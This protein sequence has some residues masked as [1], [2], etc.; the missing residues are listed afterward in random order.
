MTNVVGVC[1]NAFMKKILVV[2]IDDVL[3]NNCL[4]I[5]LNKF[6]GT[7]YKEEDFEG[8]NTQDIIK[9]EEKLN[10]Y[11]NYVLSNDMYSDV[12]VKEGV[13]EVLPL[14]NEEYDLYLC[15]DILLPNH[16]WQADGEFVSKFKM[17]R[18]KFSYLHPKQFIF[19]KKKQLLH[20]DIMIDDKLSNFGEYMSKK[21][22]FTAYHNVNMSEEELNSKG[23]T[24][25]NSWY[26]IA[27]LLLK[28]K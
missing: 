14:L 24:R 11:Y 12:V 26:E 2:D 8:Y 20:A 18:E 15:T 4:L 5:M 21:L 25:V 7:N 19:M 3:V 1:Y 6:L 23:V 9:D 27:D 28:E 16:E 10:E 22:L 13:H 17:L